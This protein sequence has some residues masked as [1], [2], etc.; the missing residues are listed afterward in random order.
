MWNLEGNVR[1]PGL[2]ILVPCKR[3]TSAGL[4]IAIEI[5]PTIMDKSPNG[6]VMQYSYCSVISWFPRKTVHPFRSFLAVLPPPTLYKVK[7][8]KKLWIFASNVVCGERGG[9]GHV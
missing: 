4:M 9:V 6:T 8:R 7:P 5:N 1:H 2:F 3:G